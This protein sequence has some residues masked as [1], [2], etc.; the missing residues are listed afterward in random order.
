MD[1]LKENGLKLYYC[2]TDCLFT[3]Q[4]LEANLNF[5]ELIGDGIGQLKNELVPKDYYFDTDLVKYKHIETNKTLDVPF[6]DEAKFY[7]P[8]VYVL[9]K[10][11]NF[12]IKVK[13]ISTF[14]IYETLGIELLKNDETKEKLNKIL[15]SFERIEELLFNNGVAINRYLKYKS[16][17]RRNKTLVS[18]GRIE[19]K[20]K[21]IYDKRKI[22]KTLETIPLD[23]EDLKDLKTFLYLK[24][25]NLN[26]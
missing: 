26:M 4:P 5:K 16:S 9:K 23:S 19:K 22:L 7:L 13:G 3:N 15:N 24:V 1:Q 12:D 10:E 18:H 21:K 17:L 8:K 2:D 14:M 25:Y 11:E 6:I 20:I